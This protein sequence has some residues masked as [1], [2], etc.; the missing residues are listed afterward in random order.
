VIVVLDAASLLSGRLNSIAG[1]D[2]YI[3]PDVA[4]ELEKGRPG[5]QLQNLLSAGLKVRSPT[6]LDEARRLAASTGDL[7]FLSIPDLSVISLAIEMGG[8]VIT[9]DFRVQNVLKAAG[10]PFQPAGEIGDR[11]IGSVWKWIYRC[12]GCGRYYDEERRDCPICGSDLRPVRS[13][14]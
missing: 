3:T 8:T 13:R 7:P 5:V 12:R 9:D 6:C 14:G 10:L 11:T 1:M 2:A 4:S